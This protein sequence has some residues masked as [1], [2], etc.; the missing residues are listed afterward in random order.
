[1]GEVD[2]SHHAENDRKSKSDQSQ[3]GNTVKDLQS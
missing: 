3:I 2:N 1:M